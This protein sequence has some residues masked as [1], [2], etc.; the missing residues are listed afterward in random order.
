MHQ[1]ASMHRPLGHLLQRLT[2]KGLHALVCFQ[3]SVVIAG[4]FAFALTSLKIAASF[5]AE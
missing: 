5:R 4:G 1:H 3:C 2:N